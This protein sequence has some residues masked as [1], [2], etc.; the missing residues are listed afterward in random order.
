MF[1]EGTGGSQGGVQQV[2]T[3]QQLLESAPMEGGRRARKWLIARYN[4]GELPQE[5]AEQVLEMLRQVTETQ[6]IAEKQAMLSVQLLGIGELF[7]QTSKQLGLSSSQQQKKTVSQEPIE[8][9]RPL[10]PLMIVQNGAGKAC[11]EV[12]LAVAN[13]ITILESRLGDE[14]IKLGVD[15]GK[16]GAY[17]ITNEGKPLLSIDKKTGEIG[18][19]ELGPKTDAVTSFLE[20]FAWTRRQPDIVFVKGKAPLKEAVYQ[21]L[22]AHGVQSHHVL[23]QNSE[24]KR[25]DPYNAFEATASQREEQ[26]LKQR[27]GKRR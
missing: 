5:L 22:K 1:E 18:I 10:E 27:T 8:E 23:D 9:E 12:A 6:G 15:K 2:A 19:Y 26:A 4:A 21:G 14:S 11:K 7:K 20:T 3:I 24:T 17:T 25:R 16:S 13:A